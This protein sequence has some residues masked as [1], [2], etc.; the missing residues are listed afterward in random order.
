MALGGGTFTVQN[1]VLPG[2]YIN[3]VTK[4]LGV[5]V[6]GERGV[7]AMAIYS[8]WLADGV[9]TI[10]QENFMK[11]SLKI[12]GYEYTH[13]DLMA[14]RDFFKHG[15]T[16]LVYNIANNTTK[17]VNDYAT[18]RNKGTRGNQ[19]K[20]VIETNVDDDT[21]YDVSTYI[22]EIIVDT[23]TVETAADL[24]D[25]DFV[26]FKKDAALAVTAGTRLT[27]G[28]TT[29]A[30]TNLRFTLFLNAMEGYTFNAIASAETGV[31]FAKLL[32]A[33]TKRMR[34][35]VG[36]KFVAVVLKDDIDDAPNHEGI[37]KVAGRSS[38]TDGYECAWVCGALA[39]CEVN[40]SLTNMVYDGDDGI[41]CEYTTQEQLKAALERGEFVFHKVG[42][43]VRVLKDINS[44]TEF[45]NEKGAV[46]S[47]NQVIRVCDQIAMDISKIFCDYYLGKELNDETG[48]SFLKADII[49]HH[50]NLAVLRAIENFDSNDITVS[51]GNDK[52]SV[53]V[54]DA[55]TPVSVMD[56]LY[57]TVYVE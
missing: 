30:T 21:Y 54:E 51:T 29:S 9:H 40:E 35:D 45:T 48:R 28:E 22:D 57:M 49:K 8:S 11:D 26:V 4:N 42:D 24:V 39:G 36:K 3:V 15:K 46:L 47:D 18:A 55:I 25:N 50:N 32:I 6:F 52:G 27:G 2:A 12:F 53:V 19:I 41:N 44:L 10:T 38:N 17:A 5:N 14:I 56:K 34:D 31:D 7:G 23:Q 16:L 37:V 33:W 43:E 13:D 20:I 1:K